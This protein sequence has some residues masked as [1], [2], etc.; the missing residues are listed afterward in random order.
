MAV[1]H[2]GIEPVLS[3]RQRAGERVDR[4]DRADES[5]V[6]IIFRL[7][8]FGVAVH[9]RVGPGDLLVP[10][11]PHLDLDPPGERPAEILH[12]H[13]GS[14]IDIGRIYLA[15]EDDLVQRSHLHPFRMSRPARRR[16]QNLHG[17]PVL[18]F[19]DQSGPDCPGKW[20]DPATGLAVW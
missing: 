18:I 12:V 9:G 5:R 14:A 19:P 10:E 4:A 3:H 1:H 20:I 7:Q 15:E 11:A 17:T 2:I 16:P 13:T 8:P 6:G